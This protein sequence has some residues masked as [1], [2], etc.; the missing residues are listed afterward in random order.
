ML[1]LEMEQFCPRYKSKVSIYNTF[2][3][4]LRVKREMERQNSKL[5]PWKETLKLDPEIG[6][7]G[8]PTH[9]PYNFFLAENC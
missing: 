7:V 1:L 2:F 4:K 9:P 8:W 3:V 6:S 5:D